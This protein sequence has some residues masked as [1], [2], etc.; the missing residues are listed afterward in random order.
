MKKGFTLV[1]VLLVMGI[2]S[3]LAALGSVNYFSSFNQTSVGTFED[4]MI[5]D[6]RSAQSKAMSSQGASGAITTGWGVKFLGSSYVVFPG[7]TYTAGSSN[8]YVVS[9]PT[10]LTISTSF[11][12]SQVLFNHSSGE[13]ISYDSALDRITLN[14]GSSS[15]TIELNQYGVVTSQ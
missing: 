15:K 9:A 5:S 14:A 13:V 7:S 1:E 2:I 3:I 11:P 12:S 6:L 4:I 8:N 10:G